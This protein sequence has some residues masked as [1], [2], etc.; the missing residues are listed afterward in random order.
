M[1]NKNILERTKTSSPD[2]IEIGLI[3]ALVIWS[4]SAFILL[5]QAADIST[6]N[7]LLSWTSLTTFFAGIISI[8]LI[9]IAVILADIRKALTR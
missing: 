2:F 6:A 9:V 8:V 4:V 3:G 5:Q 1:R 7:Y